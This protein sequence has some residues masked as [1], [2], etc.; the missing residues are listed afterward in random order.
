MEGAV[1]KMPKKE[2]N[3]RKMAEKAADRARLDQQRFV[4]SGC[5]DW[6]RWRGRTGRAANVAF[7][8]VGVGQG[9]GRESGGMIAANEDGGEER[10]EGEEREEEFNLLFVLRV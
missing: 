7:G 2:R 9:G 1:R 4:T 5:G 10:D 6:R 3:R 8:A